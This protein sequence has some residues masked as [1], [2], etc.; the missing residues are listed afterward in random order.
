MTDAKMP[1]PTPPAGTAARPETAARQ[2]WMSLLAKASPDAVRQCRAR[3]GPL[4][5]YDLLRRPE[6]GLVMVRGRMGGEG[7]PFHL[8]EMTVTR[9]SVRLSS[10]GVVGH[11]WIAGREAAQAE[12]AA[13]LDALLQSPGDHSALEA[14]LT[15]LEEA[16]TARREE[17]SRK[18]AATRVDFFTMVRGED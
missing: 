8:G 10:S 5:A 12:D 9:C 13:L 16:Q 2:R 3:L 15:R 7:G 4:P 6:I 14:E 18:A 17:A 11:A 1:H